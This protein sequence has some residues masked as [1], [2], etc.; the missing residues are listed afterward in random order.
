MTRNLPIGALVLCLGPLAARAEEPYFGFRF[1]AAR[2]EATF[3]VTYV[4]PSGLAQRMGLR[5]GDVLKKINRTEPK[6]PDEVRRAFD[7]LRNQ[8][9]TIVIERSP[10]G[11]GP[12][13][14]TALLEGKIRKNEKSGKYYCV[15]RER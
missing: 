5:K 9:Y 2:K 7:D 10:D 11:K 14:A 3:V 12:S 1:K 8:D 6:S 15:P 4:D 13:V